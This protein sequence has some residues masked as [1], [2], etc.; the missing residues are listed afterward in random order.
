MILMPLRRLCGILR[1]NYWP[2]LFVLLLLTGCA[3]EIIKYEEIVE[4]EEAI[5]Y[6]E[7]T[8]YEAQGWEQA[9]LGADFVRSRMIG[10]V[11]RE[12]VRADRNGRIYELLITY[13]YILDHPFPGFYETWL[14][15][16]EKTDS[17]HRYLQSFEIYMRQGNATGGIIFADIDFDGQD[18]VLVW[19]GHFGAQGLVWFDGFVRRGDTY[20]RTNFAKISNPEL[21]TENMRIRGTIRNHAASHSWFMYA[22]VD[23]AFVRTDYITFETCR[24]TLEPLYIITLYHGE[25]V[26]QVY[27][28]EEAEQWFDRLFFD[29]EEAHWVFGTRGTWERILTFWEAARQER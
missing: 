1:I 13:E 21:D 12:Y 18:D 6:E 8:E 16:S 23:D 11:L 4:L 14:F 7:P 3:A 2:V 9:L 5:E 15:I 19:L 26:N 29:D 10:D 28:G 17:G 20:V 25:E 24:D 27:R 22:F